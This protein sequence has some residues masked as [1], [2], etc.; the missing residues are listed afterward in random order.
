MDIRR[1]FNNP[2]EKKTRNTAKPTTK[3]GASKEEGSRKVIRKRSSVIIES[4]SDNE[5]PI[6]SKRASKNGKYQLEIDDDSDEDFKGDSHS[7]HPKKPSTAEQKS[8]DKASH[9]G[10]PITAS[11]Y[12][13]DEP[14]HRSHQPSNVKKETE[15]ASKA[16]DYEIHDDD[17]FKETLLVL[18]SQQ[19][20]FG[21]TL[22]TVPFAPQS[23]PAKNTESKSLTAVD[24]KQAVDTINPEVSQETQSPVATPAKK[25]EKKTPKSDTA[26][27][28][29]KKPKFSYRQYLNREGPRALGSKEIPEGAPGCFEKLTFVITGVLDS[30]DR[31]EAADLVKKY[32]GKVAQQVSKNTSY[33]VVGIDAGPAKLEKAKKLGTKLL[34]EDDLLDL[35]RTLPGKKDASD[36]SSPLKK[37]RKLD[38][39]DPCPISTANVSQ[40]SHVTFAQGPNSVKGVLITPAELASSVKE[41]DSSLLNTMWV[42]KYKPQTTKQIIGQQGDKSNVKKLKHWLEN[43]HLNH[44]SGK[45]KKAGFG[46][47][48]SEDG[49]N[50]KAA[51]LSGPPGVGKTTS[52]ELVCKEANFTYIELNASDTRS[53]R[54]LHEDVAKM[55]KNKSMSHYI[56]GN[57]SIAQRHCLIMDEV[58]GMAG[59]EDRGGVQEMIQLI[60]SSKIPIICMCNDRMHPKIRSL[61]NY[62]FDLRFHKPRVDQLKGAMMSVCYKEKIAIKPD[63]L[64]EI[65]VASNQDVRQVLHHLSMLSITNRNLTGEE[66]SREAKKAKKD[67]KIGPFEVLRMVF[68]ASEHKNMNIHDKSSLFFHDYSIAPLF[69]QEN[70]LLVQPHE[71]DHQSSELK[72]LQRLS[73]AADSICDGDLVDKLIR[74]GGNWGLLPVEAIFA[75]V[76]PG[77]VLEGHLTQMIN[78]PSWLGRNSTRMKNER[79][80]Q[81]LHMHTRLRTSGSKTDLNEDYLHHLS[82]AIIKPLVTKQ[83]DGIPEAV[84]VMSDYDLLR[85]DLDAILEVTLLPKQVNPLTQLTSQ[86]KAAFTRTYNKAAHANPYTVINATTKGIRKNESDVTE[87]EGEEEEDEVEESEDIT[88]DAMIKKKTASK[89]KAQDTSEP[90]T[91]KKG[92]V[93][94]KGKA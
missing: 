39:T 54:S 33:M 51:L 64:Q 53:K 34:S 77:D 67:M 57:A 31:D 3:H 49:S 37:G 36:I 68:S 46:K 35:L 20:N 73:E 58:D 30:L 27:S 76:I 65:I 5:E 66:T 55:L 11:D 81:D 7:A 87:L 60:K 24:K 83:Q 91:S 75:S 13:G 19:K 50:F 44:N 14:V 48:G 88:K 18:D 79:L 93:K 78:F 92:R 56:E 15:Q 29:E 94:K 45:P 6:Q 70:Y 86:V 43:W 41:V 21:K 32:G 90:S 23:L 59:N 2:S 47:W 9:K 84:T 42:D 28:S 52:A 4:D 16:D 40:P 74:S 80:L 82:N 38:F 63:I 10:K 71:R 61:A 12:F 62:C 17:D 85:E 22:P 1:Y 26:S 8:V 69:V 72:H 89:R 25:S